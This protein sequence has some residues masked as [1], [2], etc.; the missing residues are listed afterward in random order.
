MMAKSAWSK[1]GGA[2]RLYG[3]GGRP[4]LLWGGGKERAAGPGRSD[5]GEQRCAARC[6]GGRWR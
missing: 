2:V 3:G 5:G 6:Y 4:F 1:S